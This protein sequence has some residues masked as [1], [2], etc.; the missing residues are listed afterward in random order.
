MEVRS[1]MKKLRASTNSKICF[2]KSDLVMHV[3]LLRISAKTPYSLC[4]LLNQSY[5]LSVFLIRKMLTLIIQ[6]SC[7]LNLACL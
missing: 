5:K 2:V 4:K 6:C 7:V 1:L 3:S